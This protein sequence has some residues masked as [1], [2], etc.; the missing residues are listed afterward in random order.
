MGAPGESSNCYMQYVG[1]GKGPDMYI[2]G[3]NKIKD[4]S[5]SIASK[6]IGKQP[7][8]ETTVQFVNNRAESVAP[9]KLQKTLNNSTQVR[10]LMAYQAMANNSPQV[11]RIAQRQLNPDV[12]QRITW[13]EGIQEARSSH[14]PET[15][16]NR[17]DGG[18]ITVTTTGGILGHRSI[19]LEWY[20]GLHKQGR[21]LMAHLRTPILE[22]S[23]GW[24]KTLRQVGSA[25]PG[26]GLVSKVGG[27]H[28]KQEFSSKT[29]KTKAIDEE[30]KESK[31]K[32]IEKEVAEETQYRYDVAGLK[33]YSCK[34]WADEKYE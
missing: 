6:R 17:P 30:T 3:N 14:K 12:A 2:H 19:V 9:R 22:Q 23:E 20:D 13:D 34:T 1:S 5:E 33:G 11:Q 24:G 7:A 10:H 27:L 4:N 8:G 32:D 21:E 15:V 16:L 29:E 26:F 18:V 28:W 31:R 25:I